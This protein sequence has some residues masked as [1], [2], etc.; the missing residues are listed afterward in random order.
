M[1]N[2]ENIA[3]ITTLRKGN[4]CVDVVGSRS[5]S[6]LQPILSFHS[7]IVMNAVTPDLVFLTYPELTFRHAG[8][9]NPHH[10][11]TTGVA[12][13]WKMRGYEILDNTSQWDAT[14]TCRMSPHCMHTVRYTTDRNTLLWKFNKHDA[15]AQDSPRFPTR[16]WGL[17]WRLGGEKCRRGKCSSGALLTVVEGLA[18][19]TIHT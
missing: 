3:I 16:N 17:M 4:M 9:W 14:H 15:A 6:P 2:W 10:S 18:D 11:A 19:E 1:A 13:K 8:I 5:Q 12:L 7:T